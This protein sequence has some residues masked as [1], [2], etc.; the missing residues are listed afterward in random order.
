MLVEG[1]N[2]PTAV[3]ANRFCNENG[4]L[5]APGKASNAGGVAVSGLEMS[6]NSQRLSWTL[7]EVDDHLKGIMKNIYASITEA[8]A[9]CGRP[10]DLITGANVAG[11]TRVADA[12]LWQGIC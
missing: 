3:E 2:M 1:A 8:A 4:I 11:F 7:A 9:R 12:M 6:Q 5:I 10:G